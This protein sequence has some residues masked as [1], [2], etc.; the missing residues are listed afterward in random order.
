MMDGLSTE[1]P[2]RDHTGMQFDAVWYAARYPDIAATG[3]DAETHYRRYGHLIGRD[4][5]PGFSTVFARLA[6]RVKADQEPLEEL[7]RQRAKGLFSANH[8]KVISA[9]HEVAKRG[10][11][12]LAITLAE[13]F[14]SPEMCHTAAIL[15]ANAALAKADLSGW[16]ANVNAYLAHYDTAPI[17]L[18]DQ[19][20]TIF[21][22]LS[23]DDLLAVTGGPLISV[24][25]PAWNAETTIRKAAQS[26]L[27]QTWRNLELLIV[28]DASTDRTW[29]EI[30]S[31]AA[32]D[33]RVKAIRNKVNVGPY[34][35]KNIALR[36]AAGEWITGHDAD[37]WAH[38]QRLAR[39]ALQA[40]REGKEASVTYMVRLRPNGAITHIRGQ[41]TF[42]ID[43]VARKALISCFF[44][45]ATLQSRLGNWDSVRFGADSE[46][47]ARAQLVL[48]DSFA[49]FSQIGMLCLDLENGLTGHPDYGISDQGL[50]P[51]R[52][53]YRASWQAWHAAE[54]TPDKGFLEFPP[55]Y[56]RFSVPNSMIVSQAEILANLMS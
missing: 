27:D 45:A 14:L 11:H 42:S 30:Q 18:N 32:A 56:R 4:P 6:L 48:G 16:Q 54:V 55:D 20:G 25:M 23:C 26:I 7:A 53:E 17:R 15:R 34:V 44:R 51:I 52:I 5:C 39:H 38:P 37:D 19:P 24:I 41:N 1:D 21:E 46:M 9:A 43:G 8:K 50:S 2:S 12:D 10:D 35:S 29:A 3:L 49:E 36:M 31:I 28:D 13:K 22:R 47:I 33:T 40:E